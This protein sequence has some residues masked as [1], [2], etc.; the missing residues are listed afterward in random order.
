ML[1]RITEWVR[2]EELPPRSLH[3]FDFAVVMLAD[4]S[5]LTIPVKVAVGDRPRP[6]L[7]AGARSFVSVNPGDHVFAL[8][9]RI[10]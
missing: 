8:F 10:G 6:R 3:S 5:W 1:T 7:V 4:G 2:L 9:P